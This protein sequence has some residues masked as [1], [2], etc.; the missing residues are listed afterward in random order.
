MVL[1]NDDYKTLQLF[2]AR[3]R[4][5][6]D[7]EAI[8]TRDKLQGT[9]IGQALSMLVDGFNKT[10]STLDDAVINTPYTKDT[11]T[12]LLAERTKDN[13]GIVFKM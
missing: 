7:S 5:F 1:N 13:T 4:N 3:F 12:Q 2:A 10:A 11:A 8:P 9:V 6:I